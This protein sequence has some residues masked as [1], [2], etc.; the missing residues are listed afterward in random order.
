MIYVQIGIKTS[1]KVTKLSKK[2]QKVLKS[3]KG[4]G[5]ITMFENS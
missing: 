4:G 1:F 5:A 2:Q 3:A